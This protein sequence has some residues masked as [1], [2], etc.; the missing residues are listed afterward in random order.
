[1]RS[2]ILLLIISLALL[3]FKINGK[4]SEP[5]KVEYATLDDSDLTQTANLTQT[6]DESQKVKIF[7]EMGDVLNE[8]S[9]NIES[10]TTVEIAS[11]N[12]GTSAKL[13]SKPSL[14][15]TD[16]KGLTENFIS[17]KDN[18][19]Y[20]S[21]YLKTVDVSTSKKI[22]INKSKT[23][24]F[25]SSVIL[26]EGVKK[27]IED[28]DHFKNSIKLVGERLGKDRLTIPPHVRIINPTERVLNT[29]P[30]L[31]DEI[32]LKNKPSPYDFYRSRNIMI[33][34]DNKNVMYDNSNRIADAKNIFKFN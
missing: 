31:P 25:V 22:P 8:T 16:E 4:K 12:V 5:K 15:V 9:D 30:S 19:P 13:F 28:F 6:A 2:L 33:A 26:P 10:K 23:Q 32:V 20:E 17:Y 3:G 18:F 29:L 21:K 14:K 11:V 27:Y 24:S 7:N 1:M 34:N